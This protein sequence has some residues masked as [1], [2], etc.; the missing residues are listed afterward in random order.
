MKKMLYMLAAAAT[1]AACHN[2]GE[3]DMGAAP[4]R[5]DTTAVRTDSTTGGFDTT[6]TAQPS[7][8]SMTPANPT[9]TDTTSAAPTN[10]TPTDTTSAAPT[11][12]TDTTSSAAPVPTTPDTS[13]MP[14][15]SGMSADSSGTSGY[16]PSTGADSTNPTA[17]AP[18]SSM[19]Q[20][21]GATDS[22][23]SNQ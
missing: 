5:G 2:R 8:T 11:T 9:P 17:G 18:D 15:D 7:D 16:S 13:S 3:D 12:P 1:L 10:P 14:N 19:T 23:Q 4:D 22:T 6:S 21:P 20:P